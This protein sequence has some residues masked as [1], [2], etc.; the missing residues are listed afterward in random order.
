MILSSITLQQTGLKVA[1]IT[2]GIIIYMRKCEE[3]CEMS[4]VI[5]EGQYEM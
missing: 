4:R 1:F 5:H 3:V 2:K